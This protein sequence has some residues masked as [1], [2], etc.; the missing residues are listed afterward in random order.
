MENVR[1]NVDQD[2]HGMELTVSALKVLLNMEH[3]KNVQLAAYP[4]LSELLVSAQIL[5]KSSNL[6]HLLAQH[7]QLILNQVLISRNASVKKA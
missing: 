4:M 6:H 2:K 5:I 3:V 1:Q 7:A